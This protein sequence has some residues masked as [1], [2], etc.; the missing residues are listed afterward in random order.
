M[1]K[2]NL[3]EIKNISKTFGDHKVIAD[4]SQ[5]FQGGIYA[6]MGESGSGK[7]TLL[8][9]MAGLEAPDE[10]EIQVDRT[11]LRMLFQEDRLVQ[12]FEAYTNLKLLNPKLTMIDAI[13]AMKSVGIEDSEK[14]DIYHIPVS[15]FSG[16]MRRRVSLLS[17]MLTGADILLLDEPFYGLDLETKCKTMD[18]V[19]TQAKDR[20][21]IFTT[22][23]EFDAKYLEAEII[24][25]K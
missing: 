16:G 22:H 17:V 6:L 1:E 21:F 18:Y 13:K 11:K 2:M 23:D 15:Q 14:K 19:K 5:K 4:Y 24:R 25:H 3:M 9:M 7:T 12:E 8:R 20:L 10:G